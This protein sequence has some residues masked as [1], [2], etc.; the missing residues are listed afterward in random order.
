M[1][2]GPLYAVIAILLVVIFLHHSALR[3]SRVARVLSLGVLAWFWITATPAIVAHGY[4]IERKT[5][6]GGSYSEIAVDDASPYQDS[7]TFSDGVTYYYKVRY[8]NGSYG[9][10]SNEASVTYSDTGSKT[11][12]AGVGTATAEGVTATVTPQQNIIVSAGIGSAT[13]EGAT[14]TA[15]PMVIR[16]LRRHRILFHRALIPMTTAI[17]PCTTRTAMGLFT[18]MS[19]T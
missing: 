4:H 3:A 17:T 15:T 18:S 9:D 2:P 11:V 8:Y 13:A 14:A 10:Y 7:S 19:G 6:A 1:V 16:F 5:G 12:T